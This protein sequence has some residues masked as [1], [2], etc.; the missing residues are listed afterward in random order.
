MNDEAATSTGLDRRRSYGRHVTRNRLLLVFLAAGF[1]IALAEAALR[2]TDYRAVPES[3][4]PFDLYYFRDRPGQLRDQRT[5]FGYEPGSS[6]R[7]VVVVVTNQGRAIEYDTTLTTN[8]LGLVQK[9][10]LSPGE[11]AVVVI[12][13]SFTEG[14]GAPPWFYELE[15]EIGDEIR[16]ANLGVV[17][18]GAQHWERALAWF[19]EDHHVAGLVVVF[20]EDDL[21]RPLTWWKRVDG[22]I[23]NC[24]EDQC[25]NPMARLPYRD[26]DFAP[27]TDE[28][29]PAWK[30]NAIQ[31]LQVTRVGA[32]M[33]RTR[34]SMFPVA[35]RTPRWSAG[36][37]E[38]Q[39][40]EGL[41]AFDRIAAKYP[42]AVF[43]HLP[44]AE[45]ARSQAWLQRSPKIREHL[46]ALGG[47]YR[48][49]MR[50]CALE[51]SDYYRHDPHPNANGYQ[52]IRR[53][54]AQI[55]R[56]LPTI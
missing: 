47:R 39:F 13:D 44:M 26:S 20:I 48:D 25:L 36:F 17:G 52:K 11:T 15:A 8:N 1:A 27:F 34:Q 42:A 7:Q 33:L 30:R 19:A 51:G 14:V 43:L 40:R 32:L 50:E 49:G 12:G 9:R 31:L 18:T 45:E 24:F 23:A 22:S 35:P 55:V 54:V 46:R 29:A 37:Y 41:M 10:S 16:L 28:Q 53:C 21:L 6:V 56:G 38:A 4:E 2:V 3:I 5:T